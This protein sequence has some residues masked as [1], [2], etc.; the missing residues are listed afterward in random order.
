MGNGNTESG[1]TYESCHQ[2]ADA[3]W[4]AIRLHHLDATGR[5]INPRMLSLAYRAAKALGNYRLAA[6]EADEEHTANVLRITE[7]FVRCERTGMLFGFLRG[8]A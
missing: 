8:A 4:S 7:H 3:V 6:H 1:D 2:I 5:A